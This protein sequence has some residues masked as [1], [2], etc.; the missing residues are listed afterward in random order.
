MNIKN[1]LLIILSVL[2][3]SVSQGLAQDQ[4]AATEEQKLFAKGLSLMNN[5]QYGAARE[6]FE[7]YVQIA[8]ESTRKDEAEFYVAYSGLFLEN[9]GSDAQ[10]EKFANKFPEH[11][12]AKGAFAELGNHY[13]ERGD[14]ERAIKYYT[15]A[16]LYILSDEELGKA[17]YQLGLSYYQQKQLDQSLVYF[18]R[19]KGGRS[20]YA[21]SAYFYAGIV[22][23]QNG[24]Y[25]RAQQDLQRI[26]NNQD[27]RI[28]VPYYLARIYAEQENYQELAN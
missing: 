23:F 21:E 19:V 8:G 14:Y 17:N 10:V 9:L 27:Y 20:S 7:S 3:L 13:F 22:A 26:A 18:D 15:S 2:L 24:N 12:L 11:P 28:Q 4:I 6:A 5:K 1:Q 25:F 16:D